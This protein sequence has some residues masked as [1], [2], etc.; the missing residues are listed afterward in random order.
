MKM[1]IIGI[2][3]GMGPA[4]T[5]MFYQE[6]IHQCQK[7]YGA[8]YD[9][10]YPEMFIYNLPIPN[11][12]EGLNDPNKVLAFLTAG[13]KKL[14]SIGADFIVIPCNTAHYFFEDIKRE[15][16]IP[17]LN[18]LEE[19]AQK[20]KSKGCN[21][22]GLLATQTTIE[23][24]IYNKYFD[25]YGIKILIPEQQNRV[26]K[27]ILNILAGETSQRDKKELKL[28]TK[29]L[30]NNGAESIVLGCT[31]IPLILKKEDVEVEL[32]DSLR[33]YAESTVK[34]ALRTTTT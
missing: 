19:T 15:V 27:V 13:A 26:T 17:M 12:I 32:F 6:I 11:I 33:I 21:E 8:K 5:A 25:K 28:I 24:K 34:Y 2:L 31:D 18:I 7:Q 10:D 14:D 9:Q 22:I 3:G 16:S 23:S 30:I 20:V 4:S 29:K 1:K